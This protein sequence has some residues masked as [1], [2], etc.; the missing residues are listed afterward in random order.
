MLNYGSVYGRNLGRWTWTESYIPRSV[1]VVLY[2]HS[3]RP[4]QAGTLIQISSS[5]SPGLLGVRGAAFISLAKNFLK[6]AIQKGIL[7]AA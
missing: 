3:Q 1:C 6:I 2:V 4:E 5:N 7:S